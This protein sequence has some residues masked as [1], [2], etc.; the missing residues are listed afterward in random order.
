MNEDTTR[1]AEALDLIDKYLATHQKGG[2][3]DRWLQRY[4]KAPSDHSDNFLFGK[5]VQS[6]FSGG[7]KGQ[8][9]D[10]WMP[11]MEQAFF[12][13]SIP[14]VAAMTEAE[15]LPLIRRGEVI[16]HQSKLSAVVA[17]ARVAKTL[18]NQYGTL[19]RY[20]ASFQ[21]LTSLAA[22][23]CDRFDFIGPVTAED[24]LRNVG[25]DT[26]KPDRHITRWL[27]RMGILSGAQVGVVLDTFRS[28]ATAAGMPK[29]KA[30]SIIYL[31]CADRDDVISGGVCGNVPACEA[32]PVTMLCPTRGKQSAVQRPHKA[33]PAN[34]SSAKDAPRPAL[35]I[36]ANTVWSTA[37]PGMSLE[38]IKAV[39]P[40]AD[41]G[42]LKEPFGSNGSRERLQDVDS[43]FSG[44]PSVSKA[45]IADLGKNK[46]RYVAFRAIAHRNAHWDG[47]TLVRTQCS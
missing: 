12:D 16:G 20:L 22:D 43:L 25:F 13:W 44:R 3:Y 33:R 4:D 24:F 45:R 1:C 31:F 2:A 10:T 11:R 38:A 21:N 39:N 29:A 46:G 36:A 8:V 6:M 35:P 7:M 18:L 47:Q 34:G 42:W 15:I 17:N 37:Y 5:L 27:E 28:V 30:D 14:R 9:V 19:G 26:A 41:S 32:C 40:F 23:L